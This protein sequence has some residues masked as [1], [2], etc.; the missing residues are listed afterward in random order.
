MTLYAAILDAA[1]ILGH[2]PPPSLPAARAGLLAVDRELGAIGLRLAVVGADAEPMQIPHGM[3]VRLALFRAQQRGVEGSAA[4]ARLLCISKS[5]ISR[6][7]NVPGEYFGGA[8]AEA[9]V[10][11]L[12]EHLL[13]PAGVPLPA[14][15]EPVRQ[16]RSAV[17]RSRTIKAAIAD[18]AAVLGHAAPP[19]LA[20]CGT[21]LAGIDRELSA[22]GIRL[23]LV[24]ANADPLQIPHAMLVLAAVERAEQRGE[25]KARARVARMLCVD[26]AL[27]TNML[28]GT[29]PAFG[30]DDSRARVEL[31]ME[32]LRD[33]VAHPLPP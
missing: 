16:L 7:A 19:S 15:G 27:I 29:R 18:A 9:R 4:V 26:R 3:L 2:D 28:N 12:C 32:H 21:Q 5:A 17:R 22:M 30:G 11:R 10:A 31:L 33:H 14:F 20:A 13:D 23:A 6:I 8:D 1:L 25:T 24:G